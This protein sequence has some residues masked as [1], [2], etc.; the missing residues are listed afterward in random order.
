MRNRKMYLPHFEAS[1]SQAKINNEEEDKSTNIYDAAHHG[2]ICVD[3]QKHKVITSF[4]KLMMKD[5][6]KPT[7]KITIKP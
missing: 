4:M 7:H 6:K 2:N 5:N 1:L 3:S